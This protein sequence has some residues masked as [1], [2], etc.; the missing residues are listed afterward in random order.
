MKYFLLFMASLISIWAQDHCHP[1]IGDNDYVVGYGSLM[2]Q[3]SAERTVE[4][5]LSR[6]PVV[7]N[8]FV[9]T[10][11]AH[12]EIFNLGIAFLSVSPHETERLNGVMMSLSKQDIE[13]MDGR[14]KS[15]CR[16]SIPH[17]SIQITDGYAFSDPDS[18]VWI[19][20]LENKDDSEVTTS[21]FKVVQ[22]YVDVFLDGCLDINQ[23]FDLSDFARDCVN[24]TK[25]WEKYPIVNDRIFPRRPWVY[26]PN[27]LQIDRLLMEIAP[28]VI[29]NRHFESS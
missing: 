1:Q 29:D 15:Y 9:R 16:Q 3:T 19:Y 23:E 4:R 13:A 12:V 28:E 7:I 26:Q 8:G 5:I 2:S 25:G 6:H 10:F 24:L 11:D 21:K 22:S 20:V 18:K 17:D 27:A 14:E